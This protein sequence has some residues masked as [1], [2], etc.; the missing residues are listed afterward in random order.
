[1]ENV[2]ESI[3]TV[4][5]NL[6]SMEGFAPETIENNLFFASRNRGTIDSYFNK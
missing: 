2:Q 1:M 6:R 4:I 3:N 5:S